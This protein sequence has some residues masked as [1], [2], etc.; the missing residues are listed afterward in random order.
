MN[1]S[2]VTSVHYYDIVLLDF[3]QLQFCQ[4]F[5]IVWQNWLNC[6]W[7]RHNLKKQK[8]TNLSIWQTILKLHNDFQTPGKQKKRYICF[9]IVGINRL[10][11]CWNP[12]R[13]AFIMNTI[14][15]KS[16]YGRSNVFLRKFLSHDFVSICQHD[17]SAIIRSTCI[18]NR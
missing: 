13:G 1:L 6:I 7:L 11:T 18:S 9:D 12:W 3:D 15:V 10:L 16:L 2:Y 14:V 5:Q 8:T 17:R 4:F